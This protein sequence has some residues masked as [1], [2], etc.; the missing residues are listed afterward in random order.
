VGKTT[1]ANA[2]AKALPGHV[3]SIDAILDRHGLEEWEGDYISVQSFLRANALAAEEARQVLA[4]E[5]PVIFDGNFYFRAQI[6]DLLE[7]LEFPHAVFTLRAPLSECIARDARRAV[8]LGEE[9]ARMVYSKVGEVEYGTGV[10][11]L[12]PV[13]EVVAEIVRQVQR[14]SATGLGAFSG[15]GDDTG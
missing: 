10:D 15:G 12:R 14:I 8:P 6:D 2:L 3:V 1:V 7:R 13:P 5:L 9:S 11:A 4:Q